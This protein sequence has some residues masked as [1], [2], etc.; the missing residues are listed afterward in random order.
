M[1]ERERTV[2]IIDAFKSSFSCCIEIYC[3]YYFAALFLCFI[4]LF[5]FG[6]ILLLPAF[7]IIFFFSNMIYNHFIILF[8]YQ[9]L[10]LL[11]YFSVVFWFWFSEFNSIILCD[12]WSSLEA[13]I[14][15]FNYR[16]AILHFRSVWHS[17]ACNYWFVISIMVSE[18]LN[19]VRY[20][21][22]CVFRYWPCNIACSNFIT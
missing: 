6:F 2:E 16:F 13:N 12:C 4:A 8:L 7:S 10:F 15:V 3:R 5:C 11:F 18:R 19:S 17:C 1:L 9:K 20:P 21:F 14:G 22:S